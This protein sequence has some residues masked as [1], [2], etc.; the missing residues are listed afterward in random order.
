[1]IV[2]KA[3]NTVNGKV[4]IGKTVRSLSHAKA[5]HHQRTKFIWKY[6]VFSRFYSAMR[7]HGLDAFEWEVIYSGISD[8]DI[9]EAER[10]FIS[11]YGATDP[12]IG[13][14]MTPG[15][16]GGAGKKLSASQIAQIKERFSG[17]GNPMAGRFGKDHPAY[18]HRK[19]EEQ[20]K[21]IS[22]AHKG[23]KLSDEQRK[24][25]S[26]ARKDCSPLL[27]SLKRRPPVK[28]LCSQRERL[29]EL[30]SKQRKLLV[31]S[32]GRM[33]GHQKSQTPTVPRFADGEPLE[34]HTPRSQRIFQSCWPAFERSLRIG[35]L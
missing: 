3:T 26:E 11:E 4:Y 29:G 2:Y 30:R 21:R 34:K 7:K 31:A 10:R 18:G 9:Q 19:T 20:K 32:R 12:K 25:L 28:R 1:M 23:K 14:N 17:S 8:A 13:Y 5:R 15:G 24:A 16:D 27:R 35:G 33:R 6:G 22:L